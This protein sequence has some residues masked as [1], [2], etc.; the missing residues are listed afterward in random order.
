MKGIVVAPQP[1]AAE[2]GVEVQE[3]GCT[4]FDAALAAGFMQMVADPFMCGLGGWGSA[5]ID[6]KSVV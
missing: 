3:S 6:R 2:L 1:S 4:E 5:T